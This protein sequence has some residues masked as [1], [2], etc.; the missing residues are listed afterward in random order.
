WLAPNQPGTRDGRN[1]YFGNHPAAEDTWV[2]LTRIDH[3]FSENHRAFVRFNKDFWEEHKNQRFDPIA[4]GIVLNRLNEGIS[5]DDVYV[6][7]PTFLVNFRYG[8]TY[9][10]FTERRQSRGFDLAT[11]GFAPGLMSLVNRSRATF[12]NVRV[13][14]LTAL[15]DW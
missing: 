5:I 12:P 11:L 1:N 6:F 8:I 7:N 10:N 13:G 3:A 4:T 9:A 14:S 2:H 15:G